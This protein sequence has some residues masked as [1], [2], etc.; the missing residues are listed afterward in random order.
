MSPVL[1]AVYFWEEENGVRICFG[2]HFSPSPWGGVL[3]MLIFAQLVKKP[4]VL[5]GTQ[6]FI[7]EFTRSCHWT[8]CWEI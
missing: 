3:Y 1:I 7:T 2:H 5:Y 8:L 6:S 4:I